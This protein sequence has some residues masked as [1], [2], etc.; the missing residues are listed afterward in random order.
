[1][2]GDAI[3]FRVMALIK[4]END[5]KATLNDPT[6]YLIETNTQSYTGMIAFQNDTFMKVELMTER[7]KVV[8]ILKKNI[9]KVEIINQ[10][11]RSI[12]I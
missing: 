6:V 10:K 3:I 5:S 1:M 4:G 12:P 8:K 7:P 9:R 11:S 2:L